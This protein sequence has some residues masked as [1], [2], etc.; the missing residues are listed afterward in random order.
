MKEEKLYNKMHIVLSWTNNPES[1]SIWSTLG[2][3][4][5]TLLFL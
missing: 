1:L 4:F 2:N 5:Y 3:G